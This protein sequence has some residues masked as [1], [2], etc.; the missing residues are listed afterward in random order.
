V[1]DPR[2]L[3]PGAAG[4][5]GP[6]GPGDD[7]RPRRRVYLQGGEVH[8]AREPSAVTTV[9][10]SCIAVCLYSP[11]T[12]VGGVNHFL[13]PGGPDGSARFGEGAMRLLL[14]RVLAVGAR[15]GDL[16]AKVFGGSGTM[17]RHAD[18]RTL[19]EQNAALAVRRLADEGIP[20]LGGDVGGTRG[21]KL[22]F[23]TDTGD[24]FVL[25]L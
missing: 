21:R 20:L 15:P 18:G 4:T 8:A 12:G 19:G 5:T 17:G 2:E 7:G 23:H 13:L 1:G 25:T 9:L 24:A 22:V 14:E 16:R 11:A 6:F 10:G 3:L